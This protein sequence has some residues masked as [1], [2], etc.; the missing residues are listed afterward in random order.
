MR[1]RGPAAYSANEQLME[2]HCPD[3]SGG[4]RRRR[5]TRRSID[6][7]Q[8]MGSEIHKSVRSIQQTPRNS[9]DI[10]HLSQNLKSRLGSRFRTARSSLSVFAAKEALTISFVFGTRSIETS[11]VSWHLIYEAYRDQRGRL[12]LKASI[13]YPLPK[14]RELI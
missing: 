4:K 1:F 3:H 14:E 2:C 9:V 5:A 7:L 8:A 13:D 12:A 11:S 6:D 10:V